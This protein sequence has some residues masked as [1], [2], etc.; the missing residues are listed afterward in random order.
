MNINT[1]SF[2]RG[3]TILCIFLS[4]MNFGAKFFYFAFGALLMMLMSK[5][6]IYMN[7]A[8]YLYIILGICMGLGEL[9]QG[10]IAF[11]RCMAYFALYLVGFNF[12][13]N[14]ETDKLSCEEKE[15][16]H[17]RAYSLLLVSALG[18]FGHYILNFI[19]NFGNG[20]M[21]RNTYD[22][23]SGNIMA[24][25]GQAALCCLVIGVAVSFILF[26]KKKSHIFY[27]IAIII[28]ILSY[29]MILAARTSI[30]I[31]VVT[32]VLALIFLSSNKALKVNKN[33]IGVLLLVIIVLVTLYITN[34]F[35]IKDSIES[36]NLFMR[37]SEST[38]E[39]L[40]ESGRGAKRSEYIRNF[41][42]YPFGGANM[43]KEFGYAHDLL[44][45]GYDEYGIFV[46]ML[47]V[48]IL[49]DGLNEFIAFCRN[50][51]NNITHRLTF[52]CVYI[53]V[54]IEF[55]MEPILFGM[56]W[57]FVCYCLINGCIAGMNRM[58]AKVSL[59]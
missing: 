36:S 58:S 9:D 8:S 49:L 21:G 57:L 3:L 38:N 53:I 39:E 45:D 13:R 43:R 10:L 56:Q 34:A 59:E 27:G 23:W 28:S 22:I 16:T 33:G 4:A 55:C 35:G 24:A 7:S 20:D 18:S 42:N 2:F 25:T 51:K 12:L 47:L 41:L 32:F 5:K 17:N 31:I 26:P 50:K 19:M 44:L 40:I 29:N 37:F 6:N 1:K 15:E 11:I 52:F 54:L 14:D 30:A 48:F 46:F